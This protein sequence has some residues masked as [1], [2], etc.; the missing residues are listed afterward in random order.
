MLPY[1][2]S[3]NNLHSFAFHK[4]LE[5]DEMCAHL[6]KGACVGHVLILK[7]KTW[8]LTSIALY[9]KGHGS[10]QATQVPPPN[11]FNH[12][13]INVALSPVLLESKKGLPQ[14]VATCW[15][16]KIV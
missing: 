7:E 9:T 8:L 10:R 14:T 6:A 5:C 16:C 3:Y 4:I 1:F 15:M 13:F 11:S 2:G 12:V